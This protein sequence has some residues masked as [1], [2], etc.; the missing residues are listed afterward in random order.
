[1]DGAYW[2]IV[3]EVTFYAW[4]A[5]FIATGLFPRYLVQIMSAWLTLSLLNMTVLHSG[6]MERLLL[7]EVSGFFIA[8]VL[9]Y[10]IHFRRSSWLNWTLLI[11]A[12][13][14]AADQTI[15]APPRRAR[16]TASNIPTL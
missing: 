12:A 8:D 3:T 7:T 2:S 1:M 5:V 4:M 11:T 13:L 9:L 15:D 14:L 16:I 10:A 6:A